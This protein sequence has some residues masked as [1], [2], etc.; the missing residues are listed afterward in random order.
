MKVRLGVA[1]KLAVAIA[2]FVVPVGYLL[3]LLYGSQQIAIDFGDKEIVGNN[4]LTAL[5]PVHAALVD[6]SKEIKPDEL[7][8]AIAT[9][10]SR[11]GDEM[12]ASK[13]AQAAEAALDAKASG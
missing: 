12:N 5:R 7:K 10:D 8:A 9:A 2:L 6:S 13:E 11:F 3:Y 1:T 4:Y